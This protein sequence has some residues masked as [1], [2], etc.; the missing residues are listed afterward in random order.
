[1]QAQR[2]QS[3]GWNPKHEQFSQLGSLADTA[4]AVELQ[5]GGEPC[6]WLSPAALSDASLPPDPVQLAYFTPKS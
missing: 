1:M 5:G 6:R 2:I 4:V 3:L